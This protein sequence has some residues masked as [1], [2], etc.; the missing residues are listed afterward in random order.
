MSAAQVQ[1][2]FDPYGT[3]LRRSHGFRSTERV[4][5]RFLTCRGRLAL[6]CSADPTTT[7]QRTYGEYLSDVRGFSSRDSSLVIGRRSRPL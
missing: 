5:R 3:S 2:L 7:L 1:R 6:T 4:Y